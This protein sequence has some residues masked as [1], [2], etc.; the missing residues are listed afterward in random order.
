MKRIVFILV[1]FCI[2]CGCNKDDDKDIANVTPPQ[3]DKPDT[4]EN[5][6]DSPNGDWATEKTGNFIDTFIGTGMTIG[7]TY[8]DWSIPTFTITFGSNE[9]RF[10]YSTNDTKY[11]AY[12]KYYCDTAYIWF[13]NL[14]PFETVCL[15][16]LDSISITTDT[17]FD[18]E[19]P[20][21]SILNDLFTVQYGA[22]HSYIKNNYNNMEST[23][24]YCHTD[25]VV[26]ASVFKGV[27]LLNYGT[28]FMLSK[29]P[30]K[31]KYTFT[32]TLNF[33]E[34][35]LTGEKVEVPP[36]SIEVEF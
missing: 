20:K 7:L 30:A 16:P 27:S 14:S 3:T 21:G 8:H 2:L 19:H 11:D 33:G 4:S 9:A 34:D 12:A 13:H 6:P 17:D 24:D 23:G 15:M 25:S 31:G 29:R 18:N 22:Y 10:S 26:S 35:P 5:V 28:E 1:A 32:F 36:A